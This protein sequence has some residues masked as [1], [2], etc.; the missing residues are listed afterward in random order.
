MVAAVGIVIL[1]FGLIAW[2]GQSL[3]FIAPSTAVRLGVLEPREE[4]DPAFYT[5]RKI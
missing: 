3:A 5:V 2:I 4:I 1:V